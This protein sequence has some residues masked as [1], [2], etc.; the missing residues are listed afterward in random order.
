[1]GA[2]LPGRAKCPHRICG[3]RG[4]CPTQF[5]RSSIRRLD[6]IHKDARISGHEGRGT[7]DQFLRSDCVQR[8]EFDL[9]APG[10]EFCDGQQVSD[11]LR[12]N[13]LRSRRQNQMRVRQL[14]EG[15]GFDDLDETL[16]QFLGVIHKEDLALPSSG[17][18]LQE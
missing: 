18:D 2:S 8:L 16:R 7:S 11:H 4:D 9:Q 12:T 10:I 5:G 13:I 3:I 17:M 15:N 1:M 14:S 6:K